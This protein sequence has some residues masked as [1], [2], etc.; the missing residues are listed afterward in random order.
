MG[1]TNE[2]KVERILSKLDKLDDELFA[3]ECKSD[4][5]ELIN[6]IK[7]SICQVVFPFHRNASVRV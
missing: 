2:E 6:Q 3:I 5:R 1:G 4:T 7:M